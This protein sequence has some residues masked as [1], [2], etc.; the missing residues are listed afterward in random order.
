[1]MPSATTTK[2]WDRGNSCVGLSRKCTVVGPDHVGPIPGVP[3]GSSWRFRI[4]VAEAGV[5]RPPVAGISGKAATGAVSIV[6]AAGYPEDKDEGLEFT[7]TG[8]GGRE[9]KEGNKRIAQQT[10]NQELTGVNEA[11][12]RTCDCPISLKGGVAKNWKKSRGIRVVRSSKLKKHNAEFAPEAGNRYD[13]IYKIVKYWPEKGESGYDVWR[14]LMRRDDPE[15]APWTQEGKA[16]TKAL[17]LEMYDPDVTP[18]ALNDRNYEI[19]KGISDLMAEDSANV[20]SWNAIHQRKLSSLSEFLEAVFGDVFSCAICK[21]KLVSP[22]TSSCGHNT[23]QRCLSDAFKNM[24][25]QC[26]TCRADLSKDLNKVNIQLE[27]VFS[28]LMTLAPADDEKAAG[29]PGSKD[30]KPLSSESS[31]TKA[32]ENVS[33]PPTQT[34][35]SPSMTS[36][37]RRAPVNTQSNDSSKK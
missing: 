3:V 15:P 22:V 2:D 4:N 32:M 17:G 35:L 1:M 23:C 19:P 34:D 7:Y 13:G 36:Q 20:R 25:K 31:I 26:P 9:L 28:K 33:R 30:L 27:A 14:Y 37:K 10:K 11:L 8:A 12:A 5:H 18:K 21:D 29:E 16:R 24:G 6:L